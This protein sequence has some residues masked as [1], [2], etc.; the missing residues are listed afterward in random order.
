M[1]GARPGSRGG[2]TLVELLVGISVI[3]I[4]MAILLPVLDKARR[5]A[6]VLQGMN[7]QKQIV[8]SVSEYASDHD[9]RYPPSMATI[10]SFGTW[11]W[12]HPTMITACQ[13]RPSWKYRSMSSFLGGYIEDP[14]ILLCPGVPRK[15]EYL[16]QAWDSGEQWT[17]PETSF[18]ADSLYGSYC[19][20]WNYKGYLADDR[21][22]KGPR[23]TMGS[24]GYSKL[25]V[26][27]YFGYDH[28]RS[29]GAYGSCEKFGGAGVT[30]ETETSPS[31]WSRPDPGRTTGLDGLG[32]KLHAGYTD[33]H[34]GSFKASDAVPMKVST[35]SDGSVP[36]TSGIGTSPG[37]IFI[38]PNALY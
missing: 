14:S 25:L 17:H 5:S 2:F 9:E 16:Q 18:A 32:L 15:Y 35:S 4:L 7:N 3:S 13:R 28:H 27:D 34:V 26:T 1:F 20:Y 19:L 24:R 33:G 6:R 31:Y 29:P 21:T 23:D 8:W 36:Y 22:F 38:P 37:D 12:Q 30:P 10:T 11:W